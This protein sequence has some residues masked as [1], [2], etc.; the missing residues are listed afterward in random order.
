MDW[1]SPL[2]TDGIVILGFVITGWFQK[3]KIDALKQNV[4]SLESTVSA[5]EKVVK[6]MESA[7]NIIDVKKYSEHIRTFEELVE[8]NA[9]KTVEAMEK[10]FKDDQKQMDE[11]IN[12][13]VAKIKS[14]SDAFNKATLILQQGK[15]KEEKPSVS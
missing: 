14:L 8:A 4:C 7:S 6:A 13:E 3:K 9:K 5:Q 1:S 10:Q 2:I 12:K 11:A 15:H